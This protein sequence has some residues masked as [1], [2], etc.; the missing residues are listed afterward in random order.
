MRESRAGFHGGVQGYFES[1][2]KGPIILFVIVSFFLDGGLLLLELSLHSEDSLIDGIIRPSFTSSIFGSWVAEPRMAIRLAR[3][4]SSTGHRV[5][6]YGM[7]SGT[8]LDPLDF[9]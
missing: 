9:P 3:S 8:L 1:N 4:W 6:G 5:V 2:N 7:F